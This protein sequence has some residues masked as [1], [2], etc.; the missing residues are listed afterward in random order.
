MEPFRDLSWAIP[1]GI[2]EF[3]HWPEKCIA[4]NVFQRG[5]RQEDAMILPKVFLVGVFFLPTPVGVSTNNL[6][7]GGHMLG[8]R[9]SEFKRAFPST[10]CGSPLHETEVKD[11]SDLADKTTLLG[12][13]L[14]DPEQIETAFSTTGQII[15]TALSHVLATFYQEHLIGLR[16][17]VCFPEIDTLVSHFTK[18]IGRATLNLTVKFD[19]TN[20]R[21][22]VAWSNGTD[23]L[24]LVSA[25]V[26]LD[27]DSTY[28][29]IMSGDKSIVLVVVIVHL[30]RLEK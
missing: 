2:S 24:S 18:E 10:V 21:R 6:S 3:K 22:L 28:P 20:P 4:L 13:C 17:V 16:F 30:W 12:C 29:I 7:L 15:S 8:E 9:L 1:L 23:V 25:T 26:P 11:N 5:T 19:G 27:E 14:D